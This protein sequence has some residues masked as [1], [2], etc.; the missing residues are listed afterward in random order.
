MN[1]QPIEKNAGS[2]LTA[3]AEYTDTAAGLAELRQKHQGVVYD[4]TVP[5]QMKAAKEARAELRT[6]RTTLEKTRKEIK[7]PALERCRMIDEEAK[8]I[9]AEI[10]ALEEP[11]DIQIKAEEARA[12][13]ERL[14]KL[15]AE[16]LRVEAIQ[17]KI[18]AIRDVP[19]GLVGK[20]SV[21]IAGQLAK[22]EAEQL[23][24]EEF[25]EFFDIGR[26]ALDATIGRVKQLLDAQRD[27]EAEQKR[28]E[29]ERA[30]LARLREEAEARRRAD[31]EKAAAERA[32]QDRLA[33]EQREREAAAQRE[34]EEAERAERQ[35]QEDEARAAREEQERA[36]R[37]EQERVR[38]QQEA[39]LQAERERQAAEQRRLD[40]EAQRL[41]RE[42]E[43]AAVRAEAERVAKMSL[44]E[45]ANDAHV[46]L[47]TLAPTN[48]A[49]VRLGKVLKRE[50]AGQAPAR[51]KK[52]ANG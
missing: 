15:E 46:L 18:Q 27:H 30:E 8:R 25:A 44:V 6:L 3:I 5:K 4:V 9:T 37:E 36:E 32:E 23:D 20:P 52:A 7:A 33:R 29:A 40:E 24:E 49:T 35:R 2:N 16:R 21:I 12:E 38:Q 31:E 26:D 34:R 11:I 42:R 50:A 45:A 39:E 51:G 41:Q 28:I 22:L 1:A 14:Q 13:S 48:A 17:Q 43:E 10:V 19:A 47:C